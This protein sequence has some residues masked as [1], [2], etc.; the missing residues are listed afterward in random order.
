MRE[1]KVRPR[2]GDLR[3]AETLGEW[4]TMYRAATGSDIDHW[5]GSG[6]GGSREDSE[7][8]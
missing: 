3:M 2:W 6:F 1:K 7:G 8:D 4:G 5:D